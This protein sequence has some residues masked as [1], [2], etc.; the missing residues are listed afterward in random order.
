MTKIP[1]RAELNALLT[2]AYDAQFNYG[3]DR[4]GNGEVLHRYCSDTNDRVMEA[5]DALYAAPSASEAVTDEQRLQI[6]FDVL[7][8][9]KEAAAKRGDFSLAADLRGGSFRLQQIAGARRSPAG[10]GDS[11][12]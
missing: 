8:Q 2:A 5:L 10:R 6:A 1:T 9:E 11:G 4:D 7:E 3:D 12:T